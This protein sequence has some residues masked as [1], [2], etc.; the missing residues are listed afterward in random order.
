MIAI[1]SCNDIAWKDLAASIDVMKSGVPDFF[2][3]DVIYR[4]NISGKIYIKWGIFGTQVC[5]NVTRGD[6]LT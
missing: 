1:N 2:N 3:N 6:N 5:I 4:V